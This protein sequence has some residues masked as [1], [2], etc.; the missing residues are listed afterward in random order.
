MRLAIFV[1]PPVVGTVKTRLASSCGDERAAQL[2]EAFVEDTLTAT[3]TLPGVDRALFC[4]GD[5]HHP[6]I[7]AWAAS[8]AVTVR[9][10]AKGDLGERIAHAL[11]WGL[12][13]AGQAVV[14]GS[15]A[16][17]LPPRVFQHA[18]RVLAGSEVVL[19]PAADGGYYLVG[20]RERVPPL[21][22]GIPWSTAGVLA[23]TLEV[24]T[25]LGLQARCVEPW[26]D[27]DT[28]ADLRLLRTHL[29]LD[30]AAAPVTAQTLG[31]DSPA[32]SEF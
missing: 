18:R 3:G 25:G 24:A 30:P 17:S 31:R 12:E 2:Y 4:A 10:Q 23:R 9:S 27:V 7:Q 20:V 26:Y 32:V 16:P 6:A 15:D 14:V 13:G 11:E 22:D 29:H 1:R 28:A 5:V 21:F 8:H 19:G